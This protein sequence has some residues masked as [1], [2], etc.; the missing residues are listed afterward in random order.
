MFA[1]YY[2]V[3]NFSWRILM[4]AKMNPA[5][6]IWLALA[7]IAAT[8]TQADTLDDELLACRD[9]SSAGAR[10]GRIDIGPA[11]RNRQAVVL[12]MYRLHRRF[13]SCLNHLGKLGKLRP[14]V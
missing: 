14:Q 6:I 10:L 11:A 9:L 3:S 8:T 5:I 1:M 2:L 7:S 12:G 13:R 4:S